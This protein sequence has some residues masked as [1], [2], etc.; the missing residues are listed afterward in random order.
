MRRLTVFFQGV[1][2]LGF[3]IMMLVSGLMLLAHDG[4]SVELTQSLGLL[5]LFLGLLLVTER[6]ST[7]R[8]SRWSRR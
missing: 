4:L 1:F 5:A 7:G 8:W 3:V 6:L 2:A